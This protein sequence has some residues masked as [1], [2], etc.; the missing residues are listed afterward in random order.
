MEGISF[1]L[2][3]IP[4]RNKLRI[5]VLGLIA[6]LTVGISP[7]FAEP[8]GAQEQTPGQPSEASGQMQQGE[9]APTPLATLIE[10]AERNDPTIL[11]AT[12]A[13][14]A[15]TLVAPQMLSLP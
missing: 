15:A 6:L 12:Q 7:G 10:E 3:R 8:Q 5:F 14:K 1:G 4:L 13:A 9:G 2:S 11:A